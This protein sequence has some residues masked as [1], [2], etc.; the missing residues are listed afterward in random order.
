MATCFYL[1]DN[2][3]IITAVI[4][5]CIIFLQL[6]GMYQ[7]RLQERHLSTAYVKTSGPIPLLS[8]LKNGILCKSLKYL[9]AMPSIH[10]YNYY[11]LL[12]STTPNFGMKLECILYQ[13]KFIFSPYTQLTCFQ[14]NGYKILITLWNNKSPKMF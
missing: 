7:K 8:G 9:V 11:Y 14:E 10:K 3:K 13:S 2:Y 12:F 1:S 5:C 4:C 6:F